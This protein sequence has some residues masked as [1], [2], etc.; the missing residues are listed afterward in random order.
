LIIHNGRVAAAIFL[1]IA[2]SSDPAPSD[3]AR[4]LVALTG[5]FL[6]VQ[7][8]PAAV[9]GLLTL[10]SLNDAEPGARGTVMRQLAGS[11]IPIAVGAYLLTRP[12]RFLDFLDRRTS[13]PVVE[14]DQV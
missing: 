13:E 8:S 1:E 2:E 3:F 5:V 12:K 10:L 7:A 14:P 11:L 4:V 6:V 9:N